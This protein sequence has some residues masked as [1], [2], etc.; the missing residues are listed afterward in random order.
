MLPIPSRKWSIPSHVLFG[1]S[2]FVLYL[3]FD[4]IFWLHC[5]TSLWYTTFEN[6]LFASFC[7]LCLYLVNYLNIVWSYIFIACLQP[8][9]LLLFRI[10]RCKYLILQQF[11][12]NNIWLINWHIMNHIPKTASGGSLIIWIPK[13]SS[14]LWLGVYKFW[15]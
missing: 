15:I 14:R 11:L 7:H 10:F 5:L 12:I 6:W 4:Y 1:Y 2:W 3:V 13:Y 9:S 8:C